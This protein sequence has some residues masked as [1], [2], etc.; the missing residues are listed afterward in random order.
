M[1][2][3][4]GEHRVAGTQFGHQ[5]KGY[6]LSGDGSSHSFMPTGEFWEYEPSTD[7]WTELDPHPGISRW[8]PGSFVINGAVYFLGG[9][10]RVTGVIMNDMWTYQLTSPTSTAELGYSSIVEVYPN[11]A[12]DFI[13]IKADLGEQF[14]VS[15]QNSTGQMVYQATGQQDNLRMDVSAFDAGLYLVSIESATHFIKKKLIVQ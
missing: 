10:N 14:N 4:P 1:S 11:P 6:V 3:F 8:A 2:D 7:S 13:T 9:Q 12:S 5:G 15:V